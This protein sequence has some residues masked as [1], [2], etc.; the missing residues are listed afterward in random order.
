MNNCIDGVTGLRLG[1]LAL[2]TAVVLCACAPAIGS[3]EGDFEYWAKAIFEIPVA[4]HWE[5]NLEG[6]LTFDDDAHRLADHQEDYLFTYSGLAD[7]FA[8]GLGYKKKFDKEGDDW[9]AEDRPYLNLIV[10]DK[11]CGL[12]IGSRSRFEYR[13]VEDEEIVWRYR[14]KVAVWSPVTFTPL[15]IQPYVA[16]EIFINFDEEDFN[17]HRLYGGAFIPLHQQIRLELFYAWKLDKEEDNSWHD[18]N[19]LGSHIY[20]QF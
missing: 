10:E 20:F 15:K 4:E 8:V 7:W 3:D 1:V 9:Q 12:H 19:I 18:T 2:A 14:N 11:L 6:R 16:D 17:Q 13:D 5:F